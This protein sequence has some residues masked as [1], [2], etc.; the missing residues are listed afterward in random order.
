[1]STTS[2][3]PVT[4]AAGNGMGR[5]RQV[6]N[7]GLLTASTA[8]DNAES[9][10]TTVMF[11]LI[12]EAFGL[13]AAALGG[14]VAVMKAA[15]AVAAVPWAIL[16]RRY[17]RRTVL[18]IAA[19]FWGV[20]IIAA[21]LS[22]SY[23]QFLIFAGIAALGFAGSGSIALEILGDLYD[24]RSRGRATGALYAGVAVVAGVSAPLFGLL[25]AFDQ[26][27][28][29]AYVICGTICL[30]IGVLILTLLDDPRRQAR[31]KAPTL[32]D[33]G[34]KAHCVRHH[35][36]ELARIRSYQY[37]LVQRLLTG[38]GVMMSFGVVYLVEE[39]G[40]STQ[41]ASVVAL[42]FALGYV[43]GALGGGAL[44][45]RVHRALPR[46]GRILALQT[47]QLAFAAGAF[48]TLHLSFAGIAPYIA[49][50]GLL[51]LLQAQVPVINR[52]LVMA[53]VP[54]HLRA[55]AFA[56]SIYVVEALA[57]AGY[58]LLAGIL[59]DRIGMVQAL[60][61]VTVG[62][63]T[64]NAIASGLLYRPYARDS[65]AVNVLESAGEAGG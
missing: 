3:S 2:H 44:L 40:F 1:M 28:R 20:W 42:P 61:L 25:A 22:G 57:Y 17:N 58:A 38:Q 10:I 36:R 55:L 33:L 49:L 12:R 48:V 15:G 64:V 8:M 18:S 5:G 60:T 53:V 46:T 19:G 41:V 23:L 54:P 35:L 63:T 37:L 50:F 65:A 13:S 51:G 29:I 59:A 4:T 26:G 31:V 52:P 56:V 16:A 9:S 43:T 27:W 30:V 32:D 14:I 34:A 47:T 11:P 7:L 24:D 62:L 45:D 39:R 21:G 6:R